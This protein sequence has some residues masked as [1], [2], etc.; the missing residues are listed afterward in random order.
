V[1]L[2]TI[3][4]LF[5]T[6]IVG[7]VMASLVGGASVFTFPVLLATGLSPVVA[8]ASNLV[9][10][11]PG[12]FLAAMADRGQL[13]PFDRGFVGLLITSVLGAL[14]G[15]ALL[16]LTPVRLFEVLIP[17]LLG[18]ATV[19]FAAS[20]RITRALRERAT[21]RG[22]P[23]PQMSV[24]SIPVLLPVSV[25]GGYF[26][27]GVGVLLL[28]VLSVATGGDYRSA[29]VA[30]N[31]VSSLNTL[32]ASICFIANGVVSWPPTLAMMAGC[33]IGGT[34]GAHIARV[35]P[36]AV[37]RIVVIVVGATLTIVFA[38]KYWL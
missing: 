18:F 2:S 22:R 15:A 8:T 31:L 11:S 9:A 37:M 35:V 20:G 5:G 16:M 33:L 1:D 26:G 29:N 19:L 23:A 12:N 3:L 14:I 25:Y 21:A 4:L 30:K 13:P 34:C 6:G 28:G 10:V 36:P 38:W 24:T 32:V 27:A 17:L 7:G